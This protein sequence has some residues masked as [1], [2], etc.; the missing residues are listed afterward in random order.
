MKLKVKKKPVKLS[1]LKVGSL[2]MTPDME[3]LALKSE[4]RTDKGAIEAFI[5]GSGEMF[6]GGTSDPRVQRNLDVLEVKIIE[7][8]KKPK[9]THIVED[10]NSQAWI[11]VPKGDDMKFWLNKY[12]KRTW[13]REE[14]SGAKFTADR[15]YYWVDRVIVLDENRTVVNDVKFSDFIASPAYV[16]WT[17]IQPEITEHEG[18]IK[19]SL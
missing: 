19:P 1:E 17:P 15:S 14:E 9:K 3:C 6:W 7:E 10:I 2:F 4:Y 16:K 18:D 13:T 11:Q 12:G 8:P 5:V